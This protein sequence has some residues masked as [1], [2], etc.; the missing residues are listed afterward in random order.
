MS[1]DGSSLSIIGNRQMPCGDRY[2]ASRRLVPGIECTTAFAGIYYLFDSY[3]G[4]YQ[5]IIL[6]SQ[7]RVWNWQFDKLTEQNGLEALKQAWR[8]YDCQDQAVQGAPKCEGYR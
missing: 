6:P 5:T 3:V 4:A 2:E 8:I 1:T 7:K